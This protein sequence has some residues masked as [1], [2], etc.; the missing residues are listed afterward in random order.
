[1]KI[2]HKVFWLEEKDIDAPELLASAL[3]EGYVILSALQVGK[4]AC[5]ITAKPILEQGDKVPSK[6]ERIPSPIKTA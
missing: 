6:E 3:D 1:M 2:D 4:C 5:V